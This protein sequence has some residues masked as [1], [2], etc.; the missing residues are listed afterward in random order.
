MGKALTLVSGR[1]AFDRSRKQTAS[2]QGS[3]HL[4]ETPLN[5]RIQR[6]GIIIGAMKAGTTAAFKALGQHPQIAL[7]REKEPAFFASSEKFA[8]GF[9]SYEALWEWDISRHK[10][11]VEASTDLAKD[12][13]FQGGPQR[14]ADTDRDFFIV[15]LV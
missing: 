7:S 1:S 11:A 15:Y 3:C 13:D 14:I 5:G 8:L 10:I 4:E 6:F 12:P 9:S 2:K